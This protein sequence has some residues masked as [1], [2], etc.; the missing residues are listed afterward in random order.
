MWSLRWESRGRTFTVKTPGLE[1]DISTHAGM[2]M[3]D[4]KMVMKAG[5]HTSLS[6][7][8]SKMYCAFALPWNET[9]VR[10]S[11]SSSADE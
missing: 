3:V 4:T 9:N 1:F 5:Q 11:S 6:G 2:Q 10:I 7:V 8:M